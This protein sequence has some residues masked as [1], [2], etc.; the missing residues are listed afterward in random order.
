M[1]DLS[2]IPLQ[3]GQLVLLTDRLGAP[4]DFVVLD[5][6]TSNLRQG[7]KCIFVSVAEGFAHWNSLA[8][9]WVCLVDVVVLIILRLKLYDVCYSIKVPSTDQNRHISS[10]SLVFIDGLESFQDSVL[11]NL[12]QIHKKISDAI[13]P[14]SS[15]R[16]TVLIDGLSCL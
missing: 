11:S 1:F 8:T 13:D 10:G 15:R 6:L 5:V 12:R 2:S 9:K 16:I 7:R 14:A 3:P 4:A